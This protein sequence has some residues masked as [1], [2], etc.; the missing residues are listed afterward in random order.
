MKMPETN[1][2]KIIFK[3][4]CSLY[5]KRDLNGLLAI[6]TENCNLWGTAIDEYR[7]GLNQIEAQLKRDWSQ[8]EKGELEIVKF[9]TTPREASWAAAVCNAKLMIDGREHFFEHLR[10]TISI[11]KEQGIWKIAH[12]HASFPDFRNAPNHSFPVS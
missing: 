2:P 5:K 12:M 10:A 3:E 11:E 6:F 9:V 1:I 8:S 7:V 4:F